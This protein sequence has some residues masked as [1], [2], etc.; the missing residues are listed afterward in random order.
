MEEV[1]KTVRRIGALRW[2]GIITNGLLSI[3][4]KV[5]ID[6]FIFTVS[7]SFGIYGIEAHGVF[8]SDAYWFSWFVYI[9]V[10]VCYLSYMRGQVDSF[11][12]ALIFLFFANFI[13]LLSLFWI[14][15]G[16]SSFVLFSALFWAMLF[17]TFAWL[18]RFS[19]HRI[20]EDNVTVEKIFQTAY[21]ILICLLGFLLVTNFSL[22]AGVGFDSVYERR[23]I[24][25]SWLGG[26][27]KPYLYSWS[28]Y[29][30]SMYL[31]FVSRHWIF[32]CIGICY[33][34]VFY[35]VAG[36]KVYLFLP[37]LVLMIKLVPKLGGKPVLYL[38]FIVLSVLGVLSFILGDIWVPSLV[39]R[40]FAMPPDIALNYVEFFEYENLH[41]S[42]SFLSGVSGYP[43]AELPATLIGYVYYTDG[44]NATVNFLADAYLNMGWFAIC[45]LLLFFAFLRATLRD[46]RYLIL[47]V[48]IFIQ[49]IDTPLPTILLTGGGGLIIITC[50]L[51]NARLVTGHVSRYE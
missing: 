38:F 30:F 17:I 35:I 7:P 19:T 37:L 11:D 42:Y 49:A 48:P 46:S 1:N 32:K 41:Y 6:F 4:A 15:E 29:V 33:I 3:L 31:M 18:P 12:C 20:A 13:P 8:F 5:V 23:S 40:L 2:D 10:L 51:L 36:D 43:Y 27:L 39:H 45:P 26:G 25:S 44:D 34:L 16:S 22:S 21:C 50:Y 47:L 14:E 28:V 9:G 24:F